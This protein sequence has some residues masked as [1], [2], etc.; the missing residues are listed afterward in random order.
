MNKKGGIIVAKRQYRP[1]AKLLAEKL[2][3]DYTESFSEIDTQYDYCFRYGNITTYVPNVLLTINH[4]RAI[5]ISSNK[6]QCRVLLQN[7][8]YPCPKVFTKRNILDAN[9]PIIARPVHHW[10]GRDFYLINT[11][12]SAI[13]FI[14]R[15]YY[16]QEII[17]KATE[18]RLFVFGNKIIELSK[19]IPTTAVSDDLIRN[20]RT[21]WI[22][23]HIKYTD[24]HPNYREILINSIH[25]LD[26]Q[27]GAID[28]CLDWHNHLY[29]FEINSA[30]GLI[31]RKV[32]KLALYVKDYVKKRVG[33]DYPIFHSPRLQFQMPGTPEAVAPDDEEIESIHN[34]E[35]DELLD[36][37]NDNSD[38]VPPPDFQ[39]I[40]ID[41]DR[42]LRQREAERRG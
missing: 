31:N 8:G 9:F 28:F 32:E 14:D 19:K 37:A 6:P 10:K 16:L 3:A 41:L 26:L 39:Q 25:A 30:P 36:E 1:T 17:D 23:K 22:F 29:I 35:L 38:S 33:V 4:A 27:F 34:N 40:Q 7:T 15:G 2:G 18:Y 12:S 42:M 20:H 21:G 13:K 24:L 5:K 11:I